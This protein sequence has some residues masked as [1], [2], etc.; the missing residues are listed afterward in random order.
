MTHCGI[1]SD[2]CESLD[3]T[4]L[5]FFVYVD[6]HNSHKSVDKRAHFLNTTEGNG[7]SLLASELWLLLEWNLRMLIELLSEPSCQ[8]E[9]H[10][11]GFYIFVDHGI[12]V[13]AILM[14]TLCYCGTNKL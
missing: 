12:L 14:H 2:R 8:K 9:F 10:F 7:R 3:S 4:A 6:A 11:V 13:L 5:R 1:L